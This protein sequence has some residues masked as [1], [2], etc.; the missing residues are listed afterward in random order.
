VALSQTLG[1]VGAPAILWSPS[2]IVE[3]LELI[4]RGNQAGEKRLHDLAIGF[5]KRL[6]FGF[7]L[8]GRFSALASL[9]KECCR[10]CMPSPW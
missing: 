4:L 5:V 10:R 3:R 2:E 8:S 7:L 9:R 1:R 6:H